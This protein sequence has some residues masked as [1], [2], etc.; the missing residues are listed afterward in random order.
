MP[1]PVTRSKSRSK[2]ADFA[3]VDLPDEELLDIRL[4]DL[5]LK[6][7]GTWLE[8]Q[9]AQLYEELEQRQIALRPH[10]WLAEEWFSPDGI[11]GI[12]IPFFLAHPRLMKLER[13]FML[14]VEGGTPQWCMKILRHE[15]GHCVDTAYRLHRRHAW[16][17]I[18]GKSSQPYPEYYQPRPYS[19]SFVL[20]LDPWYA[21]SHPSEDF[22]ETFAVWLKPR[23]RWRAEYECWP[24]RKKLEFVDE[25]FEELRGQ[26]PLVTSRQHAWPLRQ[27][28]R[29]LRQHYEEK[30]QRYL[31]DIPEIFDR[32]LLR[33][34]S[35]AVEFGRN[36]TAAS[37]LRQH[38]SEIR[39]AIAHWTGQYQYVIDQVIGD[40]IAR[41]RQLK[42]RLRHSARQTRRDALVMITVQT[43]NYLHAGHHR[44]AL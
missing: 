32:D 42:L 4:C 16:Q 13:K 11:P 36:P 1:R 2:S 24:A 43:M 17:R 14:E 20:H 8:E 22:A 9:I 28:T 7:E 5:G 26:K 38:R 3:W 25:L 39:Q 21:Q 27:Q 12:A 41:C 29:T 30:C 23:S 6:V 34:F 18:F 40:M 44:V 19:K 10:V 15:T 31:L 37:F 33:L 35:D